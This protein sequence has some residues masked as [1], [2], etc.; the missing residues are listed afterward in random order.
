VTISGGVSEYVYGREKTSFGDSRPDAGGRNRARRSKTGARSSSV[1]RRHPRH[2]H[3]RLA[4]H[5]Q[6]SGS[7]IYV[8]P[9]EVLG[10]QCPVIAPDMRLCCA[11]LGGVLRGA[12]DGGA[13]AFGGTLE[14]LAPV[15]RCG[16]GF[17]PP[18]SGRDR[19]SWFS[20]G[21]RHIR[22]RHPKSSTSEISAR[23][24]ADRAATATRRRLW[25]EPPFIASNKRSAIRAASLRASS[26]FSTAPVLA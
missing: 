19:R 12:D 18:A 24:S 2:R 9:M 7:T 15:F 21:H 8:W 16:R 6:V 3:R 14:L 23:A 22:R 20:R 13:D 25:A 10:A 4:V 17:R 1:R 11:D 5:T 26:G